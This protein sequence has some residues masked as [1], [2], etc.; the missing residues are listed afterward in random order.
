M[1]HP[2]SS[3]VALSLSLECNFKQNYLRI[4]KKTG[5]WA[6]EESF[7]IRNGATALYT[8][9]SLTNNQVRTIE[10]CLPSITYSIYTLQMNNK[11]SDSWSNMA[12]IEL[13]GIHGNMVYKGMMAEKELEEVQFS[14]Y[15][16]IGHIMTEST[17]LRPLETGRMPA[18]VTTTGRLSLS[19]LLRRLLRGRSTS[20]KPSRV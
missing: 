8:S 7:E 15:P 9:P 20:A 16:S 19:D 4:I 11:S 5:S 13:Y 18:S 14:L 1:L 12:Y 6:S 3:I 17:R 10:T 2:F